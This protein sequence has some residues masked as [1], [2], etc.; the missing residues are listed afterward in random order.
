MYVFVHASSCACIRACFLVCVCSCVR[1]CVRMIM[2]RCVSN[3]NKKNLKKNK[4]LIHTER[5]AI[6]TRVPASVC[7]CVRV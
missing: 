6:R 3:K 2:R 4:S 1:A 7:E 5:A